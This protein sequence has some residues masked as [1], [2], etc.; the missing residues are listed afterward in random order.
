[1]SIQHLVNQYQPRTKEVELGGNLK[2]IYIEDSCQKTVDKVKELLA[3]LKGALLITPLADGKKSAIPFEF[4]LDF[5]AIAAN[6]GGSEMASLEAFIKSNC[7]ILLQDNDEWHN[8][9][10]A[11]KEQFEYVFNTYPEQL[12][13]YLVEGAK[14]HFLKYSASILGSLNSKMQAEANQE[15]NKALLKNLQNG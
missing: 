12:I 11:K 13:P 4:N 9:E 3:L 8:V 2:V 5:A 10:V 15:V 7:R 1:M 6:L 14:F